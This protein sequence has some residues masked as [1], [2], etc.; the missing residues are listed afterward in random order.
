[1]KAAVYHR[2]GPPEVVV[3]SLGVERAHEDLR[4]LPHAPNE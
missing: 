4:V 1:M 3:T 2:F